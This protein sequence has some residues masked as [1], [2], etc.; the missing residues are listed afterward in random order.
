M[1]VGTKNFPAAKFD[2][3]EE[4]SAAIVLTE[5]ENGVVAKLKVREGIWARG[6]NIQDFR[7][8][9]GMSLGF[10]SGR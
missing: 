10:R 8:F 7:L 1:K 4:K 5:E 3:V 2:L 6:G 9:S